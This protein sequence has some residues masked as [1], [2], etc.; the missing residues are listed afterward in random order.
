MCGAS[1]QVQY[2]CGCVSGCIYD[3]SACISHCC[4]AGEKSEKDVWQ[5]QSSLWSDRLTL[6]Y[7]AHALEHCVYIRGGD[8]SQC[9]CHS[10]GF[11][12]FQERGRPWWA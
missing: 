6:W 2:G 5:R 10:V 7:V 9:G 1:V 8:M 11:W 4:C 12:S 3:F